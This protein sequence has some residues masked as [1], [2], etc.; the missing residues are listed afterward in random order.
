[1]SPRNHGPRHENIFDS[2]RFKKVHGKENGL[3]KVLH[4]PGKANSPVSTSKLREE[5]CKKESPCR[6]DQV[7]WCPPIQQNQG[8]MEKPPNEMAFT[9][10]AKQGSVL[11]VDQKE[12]FLFLN[13]S[14]ATVLSMFPCYPRSSLDSNGLFIGYFHQFPLWLS[15]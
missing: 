1:M 4:A 6:W 13:E 14:F 15:W 10:P 2:L 8:L 9:V 7:L 12:C 11:S 3:G 5:K